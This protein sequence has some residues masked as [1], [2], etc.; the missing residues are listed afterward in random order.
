MILLAVE[1]RLTRA[2][3]A[4][5]IR[6]VVSPVGPPSLGLQECGQRC[7]QPLL[8]SVPETKILPFTDLTWNLGLGREG[9]GVTLAS[10]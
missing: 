4:Q 6:P 5:Q 7:Q 1:E 2:R 9:L 8:S 10:G 3:L